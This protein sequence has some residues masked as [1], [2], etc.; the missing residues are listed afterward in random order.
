[1]FFA[2]LALKLLRFAFIVADSPAFGLPARPRYFSNLL[3]LLPE[4]DNLFLAALT[5]LNDVRLFWMVRC[6]LWPVAGHVLFGDGFACH[7]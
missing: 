1:M 7:D 2:C 5:S 4:T 6:G 3:A